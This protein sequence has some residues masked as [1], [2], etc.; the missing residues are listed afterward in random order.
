MLVA[1]GAA[2]LIGRSVR[3]AD[4]IA[5]DV[6]T[7]NFVVDPSASDAVADTDPIEAP[8][9]AP[10]PSPEVTSS[11][12]PTHAFRHG[13]ESAVPASR[14]PAIRQCIPAEERAPSPHRSGIA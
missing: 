8:I 10:A 3:L 1:I 12:L 14:Q 4:R 11:E 6:E 7:A 9:P 13:K 2:L 5:D